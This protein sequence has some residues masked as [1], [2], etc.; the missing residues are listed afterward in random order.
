VPDH[1]PDHEEIDMTATQESTS[2]NPPKTGIAFDSTELDKLTRRIAQVRGLA[3]FLYVSGEA[4]CAESG[5][6]LA[7]DALPMLGYV[8]R[9]LV[10]EI[11]V[12]A[13]AIWARAEQHR[14]ALENLQAVA[15]AAT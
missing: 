3:S 2:T 13:E 9:D 5:Y 15:N 1:H 14:K 10:A 11:E 6:E 4:S 8:I 12:S 7:D